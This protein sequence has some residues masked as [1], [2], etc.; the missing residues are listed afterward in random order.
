M[1]IENIKNI[2][3][4]EGKLVRKNKLS[5]KSTRCLNRVCNDVQN[6]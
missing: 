1:R 4:F 5:Q 3:N 2:Q 6:L